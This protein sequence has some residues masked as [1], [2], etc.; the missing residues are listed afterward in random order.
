MASTLLVVRK[1]DIL[2][3]SALSQ[4][5]S[6]DTADASPFAFVS[7]VNHT[8]NSDLICTAVLFS[9]N[10]LTRVIKGVK[11]VFFSEMQWCGTWNSRTQS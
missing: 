6:G 5:Y 4:S 9:K 7:F 8:C 2:Y 3:Y 10:F 1:E 11:F